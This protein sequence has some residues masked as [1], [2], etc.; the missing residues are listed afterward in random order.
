MTRYNALLTESAG[1]DG[2]SGRPLL[3]AL[4]PETKEWAKEMRSLVGD[5]VP[6]QFSAAEMHEVLL[7]Q[8]VQPSLPADVSHVRIMSL[9]KAK[10]LT[11]RAVAVVGCVNG[12][13]P[14]QHNPNKDV[15][16]MQEYNKEQRRLFYVA[17]TRT[18]EYL[19]IASCWKIPTKIAKDINMSL[20][21]DKGRG[22]IECK[23]SRFLNELGDSLPPATG[24][25]TFP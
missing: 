2:L 6:E 19:L 21:I 16:P 15:L 5:V 3:D 20:G 14:R 23:A 12:L 17:L 7:E 8:I 11:A 22:F 10:G 24:S 4:F 25:M 13:I 1:C 18:T 9:H